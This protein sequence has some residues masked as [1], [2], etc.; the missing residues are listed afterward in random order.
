VE[1]ITDEDVHVFEERNQATGT[2]TAAAASGS[3]G[4]L[5]VLLREGAISFAVD[6]PVL[7][8]LF[9]VVFLEFLSFPC[10]GRRRKTSTLF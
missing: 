3:A 4:P 10:A 8:K 5:S 7:P 1:R 9:A 6:E 2:G